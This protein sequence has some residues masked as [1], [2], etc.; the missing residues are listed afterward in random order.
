MVS[1]KKFMTN[2][3]IWLREKYPLKFAGITAFVFY[4]LGI[5]VQLL[6]IAQII[7]FTWVNG[8]RSLSLESQLPLSLFN[9]VVMSACI[10]FTVFASGIRPSGH[11]KLITAV[12]W[13]L[14][15]YW[16]IGL[17]MQFLGTMFEIVVI[18]PTV[19]IGL[20]SHFRM[21]IEKRNL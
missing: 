1:L 3:T 19:L 12:A 16:T 10:V 4:G 6:V 11:P 13:L 15:I 14:T 9:I 8:G 20:I 17:A 7:P 2:K 21:A 18:S 5:S